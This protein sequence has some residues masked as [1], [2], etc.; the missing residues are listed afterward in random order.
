MA[1]LYDRILAADHV[2]LRV[3]PTAEALCTVQ[4]LLTDLR[5]AI[6]L[7]CDEAVDLFLSTRESWDVGDYP[8][9]AP[10]W[11][12]FFVESRMPNH[13]L[14]LSE[15]LHSCGVLVAARRAG[16]SEALAGLEGV[17]LG[18]IMMAS[19]VLERRKGQIEFPAMTWFIPVTLDGTVAIN[20]QTGRLLL[21][22]L[23]PPG[24]GEQEWR[25]K[26]LDAL[27]LLH[28][29]LFA[30]SLSH[31]RNVE[32]VT[33]EPSAKESRA[34]QRRRGDSLVRYHVLQISPMRKVLEHEG[35]AGEVG[36]RRAVHI[37]RGHFKDYR[38]RGLFGRHRDVYWWEAHV[39]GHAS[40]GLV[41]KDYEIAEVSDW[42]Q[43]P[44]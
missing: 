24:V 27:A 13:A 6:V 5:G 18:W 41:L 30:I 2:D 25:G 35:T 37:C 22:T 39:R 10:P 29:F 9:V 12:R 23:V 33:R 38:E 44:R 15:G 40:E 3:P 43:V 17:R 4:K 31:C 1:R 42:R 16:P 8:N 11:P 7:S 34:F 26:A 19:L 36:L 20:P 14:G 32:V 28:P 21:P